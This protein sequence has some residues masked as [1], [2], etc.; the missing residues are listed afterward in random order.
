[1]VYGNINIGIAWNVQVKEV[2]PDPDFGVRVFTPEIEQILK[3]STLVEELDI[4]C[5]DILLRVGSVGSI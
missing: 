3:T 4:S 5:N 2:E 1:V